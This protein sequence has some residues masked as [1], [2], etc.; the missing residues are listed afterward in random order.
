MCDKDCIDLNQSIKFKC[1]NDNDI[2]MTVS[3]PIKFP[4]SFYLTVKEYFIDGFFLDENSKEIFESIT[5]LKMII[6]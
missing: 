5:K 1:Y 3:E 2:L 6:D 4:D